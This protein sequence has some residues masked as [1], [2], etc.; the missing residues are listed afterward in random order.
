[1]SVLITAASDSAAFRLARLFSE[2]IL[3][4]GSIEEIPNFGDTKFIKIPSAKSPS[5]AHELLKICLDNHINEVYPLVFD[6][7][8]ELSASRVLFDE[9][10]IKI[11]IPSINYI[12]LELLKYPHILVNLLVL[13]N[14]VIVA[15][16]IPP[17][18]C[19]PFQEENGVF[20]WE[21]IDKE[22]KFSLFTV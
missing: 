2:K 19:L 8:V 21:F 22:V 10:N 14:G 7:I 1:M 18:N 5:F 20:Q 9:F 4:F 12:N 11:I 17:N 13:I 6:E 3:Y 16:E 15:G